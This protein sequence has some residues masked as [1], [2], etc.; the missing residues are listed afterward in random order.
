VAAIVHQAD[1]A[2]H[3]YAV[4]VADTS[5]DELRAEWGSWDKV[6]AADPEPATAE[7]TELFR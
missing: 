3:V 1:G 2:L 6:A 4:Q 5:A 7:Q